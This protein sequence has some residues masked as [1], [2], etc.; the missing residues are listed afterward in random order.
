MIG[1]GA[2]SGFIGTP[3]AKGASATSSGAKKK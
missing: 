1:L 3:Q 2:A